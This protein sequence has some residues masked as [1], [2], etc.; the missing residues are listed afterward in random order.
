MLELYRTLIPAHA[1]IPDNVVQVHLELAAQAHSPSAWGA[2]FAQAM[3]WYAAH[4]LERLPEHKGDAPGTVTSKKDG[5]LAISYSA[6]TPTPDGSDLYL[7]AYGQR[8]EQLRSSRVA[9][10]PFVVRP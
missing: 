2:V 8:Y 5:D 10:T 7:T 4:S 1:S 6:P 3:V 9:A